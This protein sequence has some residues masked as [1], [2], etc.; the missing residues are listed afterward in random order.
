MSQSFV[1]HAAQPSL[2]EAS[3]TQ[4]VYGLLQEDYDFTGTMQSKLLDALG[5]QR[6]EHNGAGA[7]NV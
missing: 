5:G 1:A 2:A 7:G 6:R 4:L 3:T